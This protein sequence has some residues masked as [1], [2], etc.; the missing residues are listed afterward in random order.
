MHRF[1]VRF[2]LLL[3]IV[4]L[5]DEKWNVFLLYLTVYIVLYMLLL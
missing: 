4:N 2:Y 5:I 3:H 1:F